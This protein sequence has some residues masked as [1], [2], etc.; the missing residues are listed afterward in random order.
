MRNSSDSLKWFG[1]GFDGFPKHLPDDCVEYTIHI[2]DSKLNDVQKRE[3][4]RDVQA[5]GLKLAAKLTKG[6]IWQR[7]GFNLV[8]ERKA[9]DAFLCGRTNYGDSVD[10]EW[11]VVYILR[12]LSKEF[13]R[14]WIR[15]VDSDGEFLLIEAAGVLPRWLNPE[16]ADYR[17]WLNDGR[18]LIIGL[19][20]SEHDSSHSTPEPK[21]LTLKDA[22]AF[23]HNN[24]SSIIH[25]LEIQDEAFHRLSRYPKQILDSLHHAVMKIP[26]KLAYILHHNPAYVSPAVEAF[27]LRDP[28]ALQPLQA[29]D[30]DK[31]VF[32]PRDFVRVSTK[33]TKVGYAQIKSQQ[34]E[35]PRV[36]AKV[37]HIGKDIKL[38]EEGRMGMKLTC[39]F[40]MLMSDPQQQD[41]KV[42]REIKLLLEDLDAGEDFLPSDASIMA[43][44]KRED[45]ETWLD[46]DFEDFEKE[47]DGKGTQNTTKRNNGGFG[48]RDAQDNL[49]RIVANFESFLNDDSAGPEGAEYIDD[50]DEDD[51]DNETEDGNTP[52]DGTSNDGG[53][54]DIDFN[55]DEFA[56]MMRQMMGL[57]GDTVTGKSDI[58]KF[59]DI[60]PMA[61]DND[62][63][64]C[65]RQ[66][67]SAIEHELREAGA[68]RL[69][70]NQDDGRPASQTKAIDGGLS[71]ADRRLEATVR[72]GAENRVDQDVE[73][74]YNLAKNLLESLKS[75]GGASGPGGNL[76]GLMGMHMPRD[77]HKQG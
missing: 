11:L 44:D 39:G 59:E 18:L 33:F 26:R 64:E 54:Q 62:R 13:P 21:P 41:R 69:N 72:E 67:M 9:A 40:E 60:N 34:F 71:G 30:D 58:S 52:T 10:D 27:Y 16:I 77:E 56:Q 46:I 14:T 63:D 70:P 35:A 66:D 15:V 28:I 51:D 75:Q 31:L 7:E 1:E 48:D 17:V 20:H 57:S 73:I 55:E 22:Y 50:M 2:I 4:L 6:F 19:E 36:W 43:W 3:R 38:Q 24:S 76:I 25:S 47:L 8:F 68:L 53:E 65:V 32:A 74:D 49:H 37:T 45:N 5:A 42:V 23:I 12:Q 61:M 29:Y